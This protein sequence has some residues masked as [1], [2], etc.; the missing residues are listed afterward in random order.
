V[1]LLEDTLPIT[2]THAKTN[3]EQVFFSKA[4]MPTRTQLPHKAKVRMLNTQEN[5]KEH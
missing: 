2:P 4:K 1:E 5:P 3:L